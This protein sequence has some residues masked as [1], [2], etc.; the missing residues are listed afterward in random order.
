MTPQQL[1]AAIDA[2]RRAL[3]LPWWR[4]AV[5]LDISRSSLDQLKH[6]CL[7]EGLRARA[8]E[9]LGEAS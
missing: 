3:N 6:G 1:H 2:R 7:S 5:L 9:W 8:E 4:V